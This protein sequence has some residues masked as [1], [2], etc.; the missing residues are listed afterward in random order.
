MYLSSNKEVH[1][2]QE[3]SLNKSNF[4]NISNMHMFTSL[5]KSTPLVGYATPTPPHVV[6][7]ILRPSSSHY[8]LSIHNQH[9]NASQFHSH[10]MWCCHVVI[11]WLPFHTQNIK[12][13]TI[14]K[15]PSPIESIFSKLW[16]IFCQ[17]GL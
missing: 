1:W 6:N 14:I 5:R 8:F 10:K 16:F 17:C 2:T 4:N 7:Q 11:M 12:I 3:N 13:L 9:W 15:W